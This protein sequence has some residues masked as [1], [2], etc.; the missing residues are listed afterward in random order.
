MGSIRLFLAFAVLMSHAGVCDI[1]VIPGHVAVQT[2]FIISGFYMALILSQ[3]YKECSA[4]VFYSNRLLRLF[5]TYL[6]MLLVSIVALFVFDMGLFTNAYRVEKAFTQSPFMAVLYSWTNVAIVGQEILFLLGINADN[7]SFY[8]DPNGTASL[9]GYYFILIPQAW[10]LSM[11]LYFYLLAPLILRLRIRWVFLLF[12]LSLCLR[13]L[14]IVSKGPEYDLFLRRCFPAELCLFL[15]G[16]LSYFVFTIIRG[17]KNKYQLGLISWATVLA[18]LVFYNEINEKFS[19]ALLAFTA[20]L[21][22]PFIF[23]ITKDSRFDRFLG[24]ISYPAYIVHFLIV[25]FFEEYFEDE[26]SVFLL[27]LVVFSASLVVYCAIEAPIDRWRQGR[28]RL[29]KKYK[30]KCQSISEGD[31]QKRTVSSE[32]HESGILCSSS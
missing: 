10:S 26:Y 21:T 11:E 30:R 3:K 31:L 1:E 19:L 23:N 7:L 32:M 22:M 15:L 24:N 27:L 17:Y 29:M 6:V 28:V 16:S 4:L 14:I 18:V 9:K 13:L 25:A 2:F 12:T 8:W 5:P 20:F